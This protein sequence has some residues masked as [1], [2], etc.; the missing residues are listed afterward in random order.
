MF[1]LAE[2]WRINRREAN[3]VLL[4]NDAVASALLAF[5][6]ARGDEGWEGTT[7]ALHST[8]AYNRVR[9]KRRTRLAR[10]LLPVLVAAGASSLLMY[11]VMSHLRG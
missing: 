9:R 11:L 2:T 8:W 6:E 3:V 4:E 1:K 10:M 5:L 7:A